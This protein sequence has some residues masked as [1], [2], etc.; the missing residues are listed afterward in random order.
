MRGPLDDA[1][2][3]AEAAGEPAVPT[4]REELAAPVARRVQGGKA[5]RRLLYFLGRRGF[6]AT[7][8]QTIATA[9]AEEHQAAL[10]HQLAQFATGASGDAGT[11]AAV[12]GPPTGPPTGTGPQ[13]SSLGPTT[14]PNGQTYGSSR[15]NVS[16]RVA[17]IAIDPSKPAHVL[18]G[19]AGGGVWESADSGATWAPRTDFA[20]SLAVGA[21]V[22]DPTKPATV[23]CGT[24]EGN[25][26]STLGAGILRSSDGGTTWST[27]CTSPFVGQGFFDLKVHP[28]NNQHLLSA[29]T[30]GLHVSTNGGVAWTQRRNVITWSLSIAPTGGA[31][32]EILA[33]SSDGVHQSG[34]GGTTW[35]AVTLPG[36]PASFNRLAVAYAPSNGV[37]YAFGAGLPE[38]QTPGSTDPTNKMATP[39]LW[40][41]AG[42]AW[43]A[44]SLAG[45]LTANAP[46]GTNQAW[47]DWFVAA[48][49]DLDTQVYLGAID[50]YRGYLDVDAAQRQGVERRLDSP[51]PAC[52]RVPAGPAQHDLHRM[53]RRPVSQS[54]SR[55]DVGFLQQR[56]GD[57]GIRIHRAECR[58]VAMA[59]RR[60]SG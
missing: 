9:V 43:S 33:A 21:I 48:A 19:A 12:P 14:I 6:T 49:P 38:I 52:H 28:A 58:G 8:E 15:V 47:Y 51:G 53:R 7:A 3:Q 5:L 22:F 1:V 16:G 44:V 31:N 34:D 55:R 40:R 20:A 13:W 35:T 32:A 46:I 60:H 24:G 45:L 59:D 41:L 42:G 11:S 54:R 56:D 17:A 18:C 2:N 23:Y 36:A 30:A 37:A 29:S 39:Y 27:L 57:H 26:Y 10:R 50:S 25:F 4:G